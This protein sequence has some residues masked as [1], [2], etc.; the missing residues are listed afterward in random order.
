MAA[1]IGGIFKALVKDICVTIVERQ[2]RSALLSEIVSR[3]GSK[4]LKVN[5]CWGCCVKQCF[6]N[7]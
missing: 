3:P 7:S 6:W 1:I 5:C 4:V 2:T